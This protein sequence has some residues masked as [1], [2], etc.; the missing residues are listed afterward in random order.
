M[1]RLSTSR[2]HGGGLALFTE[3]ATWT[4]Y[5]AQAVNPASPQTRKRVCLS[6]SASFIPVKSEVMGL[7]DGVSMVRIPGVT[8]PTG[9][10]SVPDYTLPS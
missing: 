8:V 1:V 6:A 3:S 10:D 7:E 5:A 2:S 9:T 4:P